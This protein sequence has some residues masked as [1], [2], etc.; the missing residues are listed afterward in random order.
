MFI[1]PNTFDS[2]Q[3]Y[4]DALKCKFADKVY[5]F[6]VQE[7]YD[8]KKCTSEKD[9]EVMQTYIELLEKKLEIIKYTYTKSDYDFYNSINETDINTLL[10]DEE[11]LTE[12]DNKLIHAVK[13]LL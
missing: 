2:I 12:C 1:V 13:Q 5:T 7:Q 10:N 9:F 6:Y 8:L 4:L 11:Y 3:G